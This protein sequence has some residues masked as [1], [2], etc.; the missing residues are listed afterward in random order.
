MIQSNLKAF[1]YVIFY[2]SLLK[3]SVAL[4]ADK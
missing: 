2:I 3:N 1:L 4:E